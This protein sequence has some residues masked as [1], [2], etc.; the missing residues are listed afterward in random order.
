MLDGLRWADVPITTHSELYLKP[1]SHGSPAVKYRGIFL[2]DEQPGLTSWANKKFHAGQ[3][4]DP[5]GQSF[6]PAMYEKMFEL[7]LRLKGNM[8]WPAMVRRP[9][10]KSIALIDRLMRP[11]FASCSGLTCSPW[12]GSR[13][14]PTKARVAST[15]LVPIKCLPMPWESFTVPV[16]RSRW[17]GECAI[18]RSTKESTAA[19]VKCVL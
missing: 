11:T 15:L 4:V 14:Y 12:P 17:Q 10:N 2:N 9:V 16:T 6:L 19:N 8:L 13:L 18:V 5:L 3:G 1:C 7:I